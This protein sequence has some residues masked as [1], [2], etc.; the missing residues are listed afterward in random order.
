MPYQKAL[1]QQIAKTLSPAHLN[2]PAIQQFLHLVDESYKVSEE[3]VSVTADKNIDLRQIMAN[4]KV[5]NS[6]AADMRGNSIRLIID[7]TLP[8]FVKGNEVQLYRVLD[9]LVSNAIQWITNGSITIGAT[10]SSTTEEELNVLFSVSYT[11]SEPGKEAA[12]HF[13]ST[14]K[15]GFD[16][17]YSEWIAAQQHKN[18]GGIRIL[19]VEDVEYNVMIAEKMLT[20]WNARVDVAENGVA[21]ITKARQNQYDIILMDL[22]MPVMDGYSATRHIRYFDQ[23]TPIIALTASAFPDIMKHNDGL[24]DFLAKPFKPTVLYDTV[25]KYTHKSKIAS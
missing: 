24:T 17:V 23:H 3:P 11:G 14:F 4:V 8:N 15:K 10:L 5:F 12:L 7:E 6:T 16:P 19:L 9:K 25:Y 1:Q 20:G 13:C 2:D 21:A 18:L 22:Q